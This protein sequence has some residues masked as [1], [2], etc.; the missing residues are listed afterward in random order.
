MLSKQIEF[1]YTG[2]IDNF[3][4]NYSFNEYTIETPD[5]VIKMDKYQFEK[6][7]EEINRLYDEVN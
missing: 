6:L 4:A 1:N 7:R 2:K 5:A 3:E